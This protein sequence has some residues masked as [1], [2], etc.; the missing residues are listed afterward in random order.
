MIAGY[1]GNPH[2]DSDTGRSQPVA[3][4]KPSRSYQL[5]EGG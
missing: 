3:K 5:V 2:D 4:G 1:T